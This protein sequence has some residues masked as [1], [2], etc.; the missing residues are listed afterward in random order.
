LT[1]DGR[2]PPRIAAFAPVAHHL[3]IDRVVVGNRVVLLLALSQAPPA[4]HLHA[5]GKPA[6]RYLCTPPPG[7]RRSV[8]SFVFHP[9]I[10]E[11]YVPLSH[12]GVQ[13]LSH[14]SKHHFSFQACFHVFSD[15]F[16]F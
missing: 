1:K 7:K 9:V 15:F 11:L 8:K 2:T 16:Y 13:T 6:R 14:S 4:C 10:L 3:L 12:S 5:A